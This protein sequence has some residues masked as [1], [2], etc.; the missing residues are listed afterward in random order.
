MIFDQDVYFLLFT[1]MVEARM[2]GANTS[3]YKFDSVVKGLHVYKTVWTPLIDET[4][5][6]HH[7]V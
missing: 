6:V 7:D 4:L 3:V 2:A 1:W 5:E